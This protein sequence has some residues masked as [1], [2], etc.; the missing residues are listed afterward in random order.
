MPAPRKDPP[1][2]TLVQTEPK[3]KP[4][5]LPPSSGPGPLSQ[6]S[7]QVENGGQ[8]EKEAPE[9]RPLEEKLLGCFYNMH[10]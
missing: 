4:A 5:P 7:R 8:E 3:K 2:I 9:E 6:T 1:W 10:A